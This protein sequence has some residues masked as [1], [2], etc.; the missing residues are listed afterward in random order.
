VSRREASW[1]EPQCQQRAALRPRDARV[2]QTMARDRTRECCRLPDCSVP[3]KARPVTRGDA[4]EHDAR[5]RNDGSAEA[6]DE[7]DAAVVALRRAEGA[8]EVTDGPP[9][10]HGGED[11]Q[12]IDGEGTHG[13]PALVGSRPD[14]FA[15]R[16][17][18]PF[19]ANWDS[20][21]PR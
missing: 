15:A 10:E 20:V 2:D 5:H 11:D 19:V 7:A 3:G 21:S 17:A 18:G 8:G 4:S 1:P 14:G 6:P 13:S 9:A 16:G 12:A